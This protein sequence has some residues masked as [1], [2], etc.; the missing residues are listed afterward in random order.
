MPNNQTIS[1]LL[2]RHKAFGALLSIV[3]SGCL[4]AAC[5]SLEYVSGLYEQNPDQQ[6]DVVVRVS[7]NKGQALTGLALND[8]YVRHNGQPLERKDNLRLNEPLSAVKLYM[9]VLVDQCENPELRNS[10]ERTREALKAYL[11]LQPSN[12]YIKII[13]YDT[14]A[15]ALSE[16]FSNDKQTLQNL[17]NQ[18]KTVQTEKSGLE[19]ALTLAQESI[20]DLPYGAYALDPRILMPNQTLAAAE[21]P[22]YNSAILLMSHNS[23]NLQTLQPYCHKYNFVVL[24]STGDLHAENGR[25]GMSTAADYNVDGAVTISDIYRLSSGDFNKDVDQTRAVKVVNQAWDSLNN[26]VNGYYWLSYNKYTD[27]KRAQPNVVKVSLNQYGRSRDQGFLISYGDAATK[28]ENLFT[29]IQGL[30]DSRATETVANEA[31][32]VTATAPFDLLPP[33]IVP[34]NTDMDNNMLTLLPAQYSDAYSGESRVATSVSVLAAA[35]PEAAQPVGAE[36]VKAQPR[37][38]QLGEDSPK[39]RR[40][41][42]DEIIVD[43]FEILSNLGNPYATNY[44]VSDEGDTVP[45]YTAEPIKLVSAEPARE[46][47]AKEH[48]SEPKDINSGRYIQVGAFVKLDNLYD[49]IER[50]SDHYNVRAV[51]STVRGREYRRCIIGPFDSELETHNT[52]QRLKNQGGLRDAFIIKKALTEYLDN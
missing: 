11:S 49:V 25:N 17:L 24:D 30:V 31:V 18:L 22:L 34:S 12:I 21:S 15:R 14:Q 36:L 41:I 39:N 40:V 33:G 20:E 26:I 35:E 3:F 48:D 46:V 32:F 47:V 9:V 43:D 50:L 29:E 45:Q 8:F 38:V 2:L 4:S 28:G 10:F 27:M 16:E 7:D 52:L 42:E 1:A 13:S 19:Q 6:V 37:E 23:V 5:A 51:T 44:L